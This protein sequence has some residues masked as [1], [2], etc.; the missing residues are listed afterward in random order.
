MMARLLR[1][2][3]DVVIGEKVSVHSQANAEDWAAPSACL[4]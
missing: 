4:T 2:R 3:F 1:A